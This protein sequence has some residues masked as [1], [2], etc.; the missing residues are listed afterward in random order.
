MKN[1]VKKRKDQYGTTF[2]F[3]KKGFRHRTDGPAV[4]YSDGTTVWYLNGKRH[5]E[6]GACLIDIVA[7]YKS[8]YLNNKIYKKEDFIYQ[9][10]YKETYQFSI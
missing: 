10:K 8:Y 7:Q 1:Y 3:N 4:E 9:T 2:Y 6:D 5:R